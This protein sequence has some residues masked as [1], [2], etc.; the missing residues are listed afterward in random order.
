MWIVAK[1]SVMKRQPLVSVV[2]PAY[3]ARLYIRETLDSVLA[4][5]Y[6]NIEVVVVDDGSTD[7]TPVILKEYLKRIK[8]IRQENKGLSSARNAGILAA[9][10]E[11]IAFVDA[12]DL[13]LPQKIEKQVNLFEK[14][15]QLGFAYTGISHFGPGSNRVR[16]CIRPK[17]YKGYILRHLFN[18]PFIAVSSVMVRKVCLDKVGLFDSKNPSTQDYD[19][20]MRL[21]PFYRA[22]FVS[23]PLVRYRV[24]HSAMSS[25]RIHMLRWMLYVIERQLHRTPHEFRDFPAKLFFSTRSL[26]LKAMILAV[27]RFARMQD[28][29]TARKMLLNYFKTYLFKL[30]GL[31][32]Y[33]TRVQDENGCKRLAP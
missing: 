19:L 5:T 25:D 13:W 7:D 10:G 17:F 8:V 15:P 24:H 6:P 20:W 11:L 32:L 28:R 30:P 33:R 31:L 14:D 1:R 27:Y 29:K 4:Q 3:N 22:D 18:Y 2:I 16:P 21:A 23:E 26:F 12:D 9:R